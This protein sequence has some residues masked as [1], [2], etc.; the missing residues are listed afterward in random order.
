L[1][2]PD[3]ELAGRAVP[4]HQVCL[5]V[6]VEVADADDLPSQIGHARWIE[7]T[8]R[9]VRGALHEP[10]GELSGTLILPN[11][12]SGAVAVEVLTHDEWRRRLHRPRPS[13][14]PA[15]A[16]AAGTCTIRI[17]VLGAAALRHE[18]HRQIH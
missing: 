14:L 13:R 2:Q 15:A 5:A 6:A 9:T 17:D 1:Q 3:G 4:P 11:Q 7:D 18:L 8:C 10:R 16:R 12:I